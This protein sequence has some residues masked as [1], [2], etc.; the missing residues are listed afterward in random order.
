MKTNLPTACPSI[1]VKTERRSS[2]I[3]EV[4]VSDYVVGF[5][6]DG[7]KVIYKGSEV[8]EAK[9]HRL[10]FLAPGIH[11]TSEQTGKQDA[12]VEIIFRYTPQGMRKIISSLRLEFGMEPDLTELCPEC[13]DPNSSVFEPDRK[14][15]DYFQSCS[16]ASKGIPKG[17]DVFRRIRAEEMAYMLIAYG[18]CCLRR[19]IMNS[20][21]TVKESFESLINRNIFTGKNIGELAAESNRS[22][23]SFKQEF[24][25][26]YNDSPRRWMTR[27]RL[28]HAGVLL[29][30][31][32]VSVSQA[33]NECGFP[34]TSHFIKLFRKEFGMT[35]A[36]YRATYAGGATSERRVAQKVKK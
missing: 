15:V 8:A 12:Y 36:V 10:F 35:P 32:G 26:Y 5:V 7:R 25:K 1:E 14:L 27:Q 9:R 28:I 3:R 2:G 19:K 29:V 23:T 6:L 11:Y 13:G 30:S 16:A 22:L 24:R 31:G 21:D 17:D 20:T 18:G 4:R 34:N 33:G